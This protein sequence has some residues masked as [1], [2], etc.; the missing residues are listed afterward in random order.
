M[1]RQRG[2]ALILV[3]M[4]TV[5]LGL[6]MLQMAL[7]AREQVARAQLLADRAEAELRTQSREMALGFS[8]LTQPWAGPV[9]ADNPYATVWNFRGEP[10]TVDGITYRMQDVSG[11][12]PVPFFGGTSE[13]VELLV[14]LGVDAPRAARLGN[15]LVE[16]QGGAAGLRRPDAGT[17]SAPVD[18]RA[19]PPFPVQSLEQ[20]R[21]LKDMDDAVFARLAPLLT[22]YPTQ[23]FN[24]LTA[25]PELLAARLPPSALKGVLELRAHGLLDAR[26][27]AA[28]TGIGAD[29]LTT[30][31][32]GPAIRIQLELQHRGMT[33]RR[34]TTVILRPYHGDAFTVWSRRDLAGGSST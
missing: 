21:G 3:L 7:T 16:L 22:L 14:S 4:I 26:S 25:P 30:L 18:V 1:K 28:L 11:L 32:P 20:L 12:M 34:D 31:I 19:W 29:D 8:L 10:F 6:L 17:P 15:Q 2:T 23:G 33:V 24:P 27:L 5:I 13:F 9:A